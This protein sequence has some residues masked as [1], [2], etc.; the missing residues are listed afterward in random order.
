M[1]LMIENMQC[2]RRMKPQCEGRKE[3][4]DRLKAERTESNG[5]KKKAYQNEAE[6]EKKNDSLKM[7]TNV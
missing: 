7:I 3:R 2:K 5:R 4:K 6:T 1:Y